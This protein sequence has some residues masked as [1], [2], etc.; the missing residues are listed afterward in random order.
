[1]NQVGDDRGRAVKIVFPQTALRQG[2]DEQAVIFR[3][4]EDRIIGQIPVGKPRDVGRR[5]SPIQQIGQVIV[6]KHVSVIIQR[7]GPRV[8]VHPFLGRVFRAESQAVGRGHHGIRNRA[9]GIRPL[10]HILAGLPAQPDEQADAKRRQQE[11]KPHGGKHIAPD[12][13]R[14]GLHRLSSPASL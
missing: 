4:A 5:I 13:A 1:M 11:P 10:G 2:D 14:E 12:Q 8:T 3:P 9:G 7:H 6:P